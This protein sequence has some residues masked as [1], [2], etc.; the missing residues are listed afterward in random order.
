MLVMT[1]KWNKKTALLIVLAAAILLCALVL[2]VSGSGGSAGTA[3]RRLKTNAD[4]IMFLESL[5]WEVEDTPVSEKLVVIPKT[6]S[7]VYETYNRLQLEQGYDLSQ[8]C[9]L[10]A[11]IHTYK[12]TNYSGYSGEVVADLYV[13][14]FQVIGGDIHSLALDGFIHGLCKK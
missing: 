6:F 7:E 3:S 12:V 11:T 8:Y 14:N 1:M 13:L 5:G 9:G 10:E 4:R 2:A